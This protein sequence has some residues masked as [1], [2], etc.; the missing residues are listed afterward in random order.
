ME[1][2]DNGYSEVYQTLPIIS[3]A[4]EKFENF[5]F[6]NEIRE[7]LEPADINGDIADQYCKCSPEVICI[8]STLFS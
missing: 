3:S 8:V 2:R 7:T 4:E 5:K 1:A 6:A